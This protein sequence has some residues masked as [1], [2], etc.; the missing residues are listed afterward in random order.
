MKNFFILLM[1]VLMLAGLASTSFA[2]QG[3]GK[4]DC[5][6]I[7]DPEACGLAAVSN[8]CPN[9]DCPKTDCVPKDHDYQGTKW[10]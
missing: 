1:V 6:Q 2:G 4:G 10:S 3:V 8:D 9:P 7:R 5:D